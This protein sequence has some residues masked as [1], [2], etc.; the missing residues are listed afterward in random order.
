VV[1]NLEL[2]RNIRDPR[3]DHTLYGVLNKTKTRM[4]SRLLRMNILQPSCGIVHFC[5]VYCWRKITKR[6]RNLS[7][8]HWVLLD[9]VCCK[10]VSNLAA[11]HALHRCSLLLYHSG[12]V[13]MLDTWTTCAKNSWITSYP[14]WGQ[15]Y[16][17]P[18]NHIPDLVHIEATWQIW[19]NVAAM[20][21]YFVLLWPFIIVVAPWL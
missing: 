6:T 5:T 20:L 14:I 4:G 13:F 18:R 21:S 15:I 12:M 19:L 16:V 10:I 2:L 11:S 9:F 8:S 17:G 7:L 3:S 1:A